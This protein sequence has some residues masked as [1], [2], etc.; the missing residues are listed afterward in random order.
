M[1]VVPGVR[2]RSFGGRASVASG[3]EVI[4]GSFRGTVAACAEALLS[5]SPAG[6]VS[7]GLCGQERKS[8]KWH[9]L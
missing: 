8:G 7:D 3:P 6:P 9:G 5:C 4:V 1:N 2:W